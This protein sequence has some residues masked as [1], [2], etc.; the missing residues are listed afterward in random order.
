MKKIAIAA[1]LIVTGAFGAA[2]GFDGDPE[3][4]RELSSTCVACHQEDGNSASPQYPKIAG[5]HAGY[6]YKQLSEFKSGE[7]ENA[8]MSGM[9]ANLSEQDM[10]DLA[11]FYADQDVELGVADEELVALGKR[12]Y[13][14][15]N[16]ETGVAAC[17]ACHGPAGEGNAPA[18]FPALKA[19]HAEYSRLQLE[20]FADGVRANDPGRMMRDVAARLSEEEIEAVASYIQGLTR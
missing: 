11:A 3:A 5:Q 4:G 15:G 16:P 13:R 9:V 12:I 2:H 6:L 20:T 18:R 14:S 10:R 19:Q 17:M 1:A 8:T 7:R